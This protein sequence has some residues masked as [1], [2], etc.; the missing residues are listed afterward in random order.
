MQSEEGGRAHQTEELGESGG[1]TL[2]V[3]VRRLL[4]T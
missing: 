4:C 1:V 2:A 3:A